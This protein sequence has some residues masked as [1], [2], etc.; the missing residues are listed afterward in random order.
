MQ[1]RRTEI[2]QAIL[3]RVYGVLDTSGIGDSEY[4]EGLRAAVPAA[5]DLG[6]AGIEHGDERAPAVPVVLLAQART[7]ARIGISIDTVL[8][9]YFAGY[10]LFGDFLVEEA[11]AV[12]IARG[13]ALKSLLRTQA[14]LFERLLATVS[15]EY[16]RESET[17]A[18]TTDE[19]RA[20]RVQRLLAGEHL[21]TP[22][23]N[24]DLD[25]HHLGVIAIGPEAA[26]VIR[27]LGDSLD[28]R[29]LLIR[30][31][32]GAVWAWLG[33]RRR[34]DPVELERHSV[35]AWPAGLS[36]AIG[37]PSRGWA[38]WRLTHRQAQAALSIALRR[39]EGVVRYADVALLASMHRDDLLVASLREL[40]LTP[41]SD[42]RDSGAALRGTLRAYF[43]ADRN[44]SSAAAA[45][46]VNR[47]TVANRLR[48]IE[49]KL[50][51]PLSPAMPDIE[52]ALRLHEL[53]AMPVNRTT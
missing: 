20:E 31:D 7:A 26:A 23:L 45:L 13:A 51:R 43:T 2:E 9:R 1:A 48:T 24:Y 52:A 49:A 36:L 5:L 12:A 8:R 11:E 18:R 3:T 29:V 28:S 38:G 47:R 44:I 21:D 15:D 30:R 32:E 46:G 10:A 42:E 33:G 53:E 19:R 40:Y 4:V 16:S 34:I 27:R 25:G 22:D 17:R 41:L 6:L 37:E 14:T 39:P 35:E 50:D